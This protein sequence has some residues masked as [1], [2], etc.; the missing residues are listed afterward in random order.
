MEV[1]ITKLKLLLRE[2]LVVPKNK[3]ASVIM[4]VKKKNKGGKMTPKSAEIYNNVAENIFVAMLE[5]K[6]VAAMVKRSLKKQNK[7]PSNQAVV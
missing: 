5:N 1:D 7:E 3:I 6:P 4:A 2:G